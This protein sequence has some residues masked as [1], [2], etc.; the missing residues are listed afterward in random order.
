MD[1]G[2]V[3]NQ[4]A[5]VFVSEANNESGDTRNN[6]SL[7][8]LCDVSSPHSGEGFKFASDT[9]FSYYASYISS[10]FSLLF[11]LMITVFFGIQKMWV[12]YTISVVVLTFLTFVQ[13]LFFLLSRLMQKE[14]GVDQKL[15]LPPRRVGFYILNRAK[16]LIRMASVVFLKNDRRQHANAIYS[17][18]PNKVITSTVYQLRCKDTSGKPTNRPEREKHWKDIV[19]YTGNIGNSIIKNSNKS[20]SFGTTL[21]FTKKDKADDMLHSV[22]ACGEYTTC[23]NL[24]AYIVSQYGEKA[25]DIPLFNTLL[26]F[27]EKFQTNPHFLIEERLENLKTLNE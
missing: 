10:A 5:S 12:W 15:Y 21:W 4:G 6:H 2:I 16:S 19:K 22:I 8:F 11:V 24:I 17:A 14:T 7:Y 9:L 23:Y 13:F 3:D 20:A 18:F 26:S 27:W 25:T 1:G